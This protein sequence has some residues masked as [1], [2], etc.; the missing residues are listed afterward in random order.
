MTNAFANKLILIVDDSIS[1]RH[2]LKGILRSGGFNN[3]VES[4]DG[5]QA[6]KVLGK[7]E[8]GLIICDWE[9]PNMNGMELFEVILNDENIN[10][11]PFIL[12][13]AQVDKKKVTEALAKGIKNYIIKPFTPEVVINKVREVLK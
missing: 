10:N 6:L 12:L 4:G 7:G 3:I 1:I 8:I 2:L 11:T 13:T 5:Q 9:M